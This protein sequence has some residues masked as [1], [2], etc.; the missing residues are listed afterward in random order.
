MSKQA[1]ACLQSWKKHCPDYQI[2]RWD[3]TNSPLNDNDYVAQAYRAKKWAFVSDYVRLKAIYEHGGIYLDTDVE[4]IK[5]LDVFLDC[6]AFI[7]F[8]ANDKIATCLM[9]CTPNHSFFGSFLDTYSKRHFIRSDGSYDETT[10]VVA[11]TNHLEQFGL[12]KNGSLQNIADVAVY[13]VEY[14]SPKNLETGKITITPNTHSIHYFNA[15]WMSKKQRFNT[16]LAQLLGPKLTKILKT[17]KK[18]GV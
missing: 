9:A 11:I 1:E 16:K 4:I 14:F 3:E 17:I 6:D 13:P 12:L 8:E 18:R 2:M 10:N 7:G 15:S 5:P